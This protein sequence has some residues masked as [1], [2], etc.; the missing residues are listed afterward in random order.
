[1]HNV[2]EGI[3]ACAAYQGRIGAHGKDDG[4]TSL[5]VSLNDHHEYP[6]EAQILMCTLSEWGFRY[7]TQQKNRG[8][9]HIGRLLDARSRRAPSV[10]A[11]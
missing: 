3:G 6:G 9:F 11:V 5:A 7:G 2:C 10:Y 4:T 1:M 8:Y